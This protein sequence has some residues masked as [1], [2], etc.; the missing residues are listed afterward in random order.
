MSMTVDLS[1]AFLPDDDEDEVTPQQPRR[2]PLPRTN[3]LWDPVP[4]PCLLAYQDRK[5]GTVFPPL[6]RLYHYLRIKSRRGAWPVKLTN[7]MASEI[8]LARQQKAYH[9]RQ[10]EELQLVKVTRSGKRSV[11]V[12]MTPFS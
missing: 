9:L 2:R 7:A 3:G 1:D 8:G 12:E 5:W 6:S 11:V 4:L 10:L